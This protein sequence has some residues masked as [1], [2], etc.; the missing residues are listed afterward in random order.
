MSNN[1]SQNNKNINKYNR[2][3]ADGKYNL[4]QKFF[5][6]LP[7]YKLAQTCNELTCKNPII[8]TFN[9]Y[10]MDVIAS[11][12]GYALINIVDLSLASIEE[13]STMIHKGWI[14]NYIYWRDNKPWISRN[15][16]KP[17]DA[18]GDERRESFVTLSFNELDKTRQARNLLWAK[19]LKTQ[20]TKLIIKDAIKQSDEWT[21]VKKR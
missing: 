16:S 3:T 5:N 8:L 17:H 2:T 19:F 12:I 15:F 1:T 18:L 9:S 7:L 10:G 11:S 21:V 20:A 6:E 4:A 13:I 14:E